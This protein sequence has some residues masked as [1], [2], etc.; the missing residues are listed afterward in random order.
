MNAVVGVIQEGKAQRALEA[1]KKLSSPHALVLRD[2]QLEK[3][4]ARQLVPGDIVRLGAGDMVPADLRLTVSESLKIDEA[5]LTGESVPSVKDAKFLAPK[6]LGAGDCKNLAF[7]STNVIAGR[8]EGIV[9][10][11][12]M[13]TQI[14]RIAG[15]I[16]QTGQEAT[17]LQR[18]LGD[19][20]KILSIVAVILCVA[21]FGIAVLQQRNI[22]EMLI[23]A[24]SLAVAAVPEGLPAIVTIVL[25]LSVSRMVKVPYHYPA[26][27]LCGNFGSC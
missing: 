5:A 22:P 7:M 9:I 20:G 23:T 15:L 12:G 18:R 8:G 6:L 1:L 19:L 4:E 11:T 10:A 26:F 2:G 3:I 21:L 14:G 17:P 13:D 24:I 16:H 25:A 27:A